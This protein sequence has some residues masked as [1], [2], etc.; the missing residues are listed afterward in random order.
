MPT[1]APAPAPVELTADDLARVLSRLP[2]WRGNT[3][4]LSRTVALPAAAQGPIVEGIHRIE[5]ELDHHAQLRQGPDDL[6][7]TL[8]THSRDAVTDLDVRLAERISDVLT[9]L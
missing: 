4:R 9:R 1:P 2:G 6:T 8:W 7:V 5:A 3:R